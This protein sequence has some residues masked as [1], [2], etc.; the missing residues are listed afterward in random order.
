[1][2]IKEGEEF[3][4]SLPNFKRQKTSEGGGWG[5]ENKYNKRSNHK[6]SDKENWSGNSSRNNFGGDDDEGK[7][8]MFQEYVIL[9]REGKIDEVTIHYA[10]IAS[11]QMLG[12][13]S[14]ENYHHLCMIPPTLLTDAT[15]VIRVFRTILNHKKR[16][17][18]DYI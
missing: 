10:D 1:M 5:D 11:L 17:I 9:E 7:P 2:S 6:F 12:I 3:Q 14:L 13:I 15:Y 16:K 8:R 18:F 4:V